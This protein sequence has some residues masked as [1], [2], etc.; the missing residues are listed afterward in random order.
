M[1]PDPVVVLFLYLFLRQ[2]EIVGW[3]E[4]IEQTNANVKFSGLKVENV[5]PK[6]TVPT[7]T[8]LEHSNPFHLAV[9]QLLSIAYLLFGACKTENR[10]RRVTL[11]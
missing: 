7:L 2:K 11:H 6:T 1:H 4:G 8:Q 5:E 9:V 10:R 3:E